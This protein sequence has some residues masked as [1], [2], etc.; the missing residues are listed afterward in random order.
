MIGD[1]VGITYATVAK[2]LV[3]INQDNYGANYYLD[4]SADLKFRLTVKHTI[5]AV[6]VAGESHLCR[7]D[8]DHYSAGVLVRTASAWA[9]IRTDVGVQD[10]TKSKD[11][12]L[13]L[14]TFMTSANITK[15]VGRE[16]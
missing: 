5:P 10:S 14:Q 4:D 7:L 15:V 12:A 16:S 6:G 13:A 1:T 11:A 2:T 3:K 9:V 8:V